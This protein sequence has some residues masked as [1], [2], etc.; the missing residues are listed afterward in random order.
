MKRLFTIAVFIIIVLLTF[1]FHQLDRA[2]RAE[3]SLITEHDVAKYWRDKLN[4]SNAE[5][6]VLQADRKTFEIIHASY[7]DSL[8]RQGIKL[9]QVKRIET[10]NTVTRDTV[11]LVKNHY[12]DRWTD[13]R[14]ID[15]NKLSYKIKDS[16]ALITINKPYGF[17]NLNTKYVTRAISYNPHTTLTGITSTEI[18]PHERRIHLGIYAGYG[19][20]KV[21]TN[22][23]AG[24]QLGAG[25]S[26][27]IY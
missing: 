15:S 5:I 18:I 13:I 1:G 25:I 9:K 2:R 14:L 8:K 20:T 3:R 19:V 17:L 4:H 12:I 22:V 21:S 16:L 7:K 26:F 10:I 27:R 11:V 6:S 23:Y 24:P